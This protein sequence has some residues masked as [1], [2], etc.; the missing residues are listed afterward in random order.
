MRML[1]HNKN[2]LAG[3]KKFILYSNLFKMYI[4]NNIL[5]FLHQ[6]LHGFK[7]HIL[8]MDIV[9]CMIYKQTAIFRVHYE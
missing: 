7:I 2:M 3:L 9:Y 4:L 8:Y 6:N 5:K 1:F